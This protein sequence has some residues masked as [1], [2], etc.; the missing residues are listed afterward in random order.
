MINIIKRA[1][2]PIINSVF[3]DGVEHMIGAVQPLAQ[4]PQYQDFVKN[5]Q[6]L[7]IS[8][9]ELAPGEVHKPHQHNV[10]SM[11][12]IT[13]GKAT[14]IG[15]TTALVEKG[16]V[17]CIPAGNRHGF[18]C[19][20]GEGLDALSIQYEADGLFSEKHA[21]INF[22]VSETPQQALL[23]FND[24]CCVKAEQTL[25][26]QIFK[27]GRMKDEHNLNIFKSQLRQWSEIFQYIMYARQSMVVDGRYHPLFLEHFK[28]ELGHDELLPP[29]RGWDAQIDSYGN[30][31]VLKMFQLDNLEKLII[32]HLVLEKCA[33]MFHLLANSQVS[34]PGEYIAAHSTLDHGH[35]AL[36][37]ELYQHI[38]HE[39]SLALQQLCAQAWE[40]MILL[41]ERIA[42]L[43]L[44][45]IE[46]MG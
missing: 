30:W 16:D 4:L 34:E 41:L 10:A 37:S 13:S 3:K 6:P 42:V 8:F 1:S 18:R 27:D 23:N 45:E 12:I 40:I 24:Q 25:F 36:G 28:D 20:R 33:D 44:N 31:F 39:E 43:T 15:D 5:Q 35:S 11:V 29:K 21:N 9:A 2:I 38:S 32:V 22:S 46:N 19:D 17:I 26:F 7:S 14:L